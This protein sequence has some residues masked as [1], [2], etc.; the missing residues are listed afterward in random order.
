MLSQKRDGDTLA[1]QCGSIIFNQEKI[2]NADVC[3]L[4][5]RHVIRIVVLGVLEYFEIKDIGENSCGL[6]DKIWDMITICVEI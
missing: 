2:G 3:I 1:L 4:N 5:G 6:F